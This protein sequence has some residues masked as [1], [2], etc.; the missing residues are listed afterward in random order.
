MARILIIEDSADTADLLKFLLEQ[1]G[2][3]ARI[4]PTRDSVTLTV[5]AQFSPQAILVDY[6]MSGMSARIFIEFVRAQYPHMQFVIMSGAEAART[7]AAELDIAF[8]EKPFAPETLYE[9]IERVT[10]SGQHVA[11]EPA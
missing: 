11:I 10:G 5:A 7:L 9:I 2:H 4:V 3:S 1:R 8:L 6:L